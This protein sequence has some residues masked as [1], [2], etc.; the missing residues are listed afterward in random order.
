MPALLGVPAAAHPTQANAQRASIPD[1]IASGH[2]ATQRSSQG[3]A[4]SQQVQAPAEV[5]GSQQAQASEVALAAGGPVLLQHAR[6]ASE[7]AAAQQLYATGLAG[8]AVQQ[9]S[10]RQAAASPQAAQPAARAP[11]TPGSDIEIDLDTPSKPAPPVAAEDALLTGSQRAMRQPSGRALL[12]PTKPASTSTGA[13]HAA[14]GRS[15]HWR[16][17]LPAMPVDPDSSCWRAPLLKCI[18]VLLRSALVSALPVQTAPWPGCLPGTGLQTTFPQAVWRL[19]RWPA[20]TLRLS[21]LPSWCVPQYAGR[22]QL[23]LCRLPW[24]APEPA[25]PHQLQEHHCIAAASTELGG[26]PLCVL[27]ADEERRL[28]Q[29]QAAPLWQQPPQAAKPAG[30][31]CAQP[32]VAA[33]ARSAVPQQPMALADVQPESAAAGS[34]GGQAAGSG[35]AAVMVAGSA[36]GGAASIHHSRPHQRSQAG[37]QQPASHSLSLSVALPVGATDRHQRQQQHPGQ[38]PD[39]GCAQA[40]QSSQH[41]AD[42]KAAPHSPSAPAQP[43]LGPEAMPSQRAEPLQLS[44]GLVDRQ[45]EQPGS[46]D[47]LQGPPEGRTDLHATPAQSADAAQAHSLQQSAGSQPAAPLQLSFSLPGSQRSA[48]RRSHEPRATPGL[49]AAAPEAVAALPPLNGGHSA[50]SA[51]PGSPLGTPGVGKPGAG[52]HAS[53]WLRFALPAP[54]QVRACS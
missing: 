29:G 47:G 43:S 15:V 51:P 3:R 21:R 37:L 26:R 25:L 18:C 5:S 46:Q 14:C 1:A 52:S 17:P 27:G 50:G 24:P 22:C 10:P 6:S 35:P 49:R 2:S 41:K 54:T 45:S 20:S 32:E 40:L 31:G 7:T 30:V 33:A 9:G 53:V 13:T 28:V 12:S 44:L 36:T 34:P 16:G 38:Q 42:P 8:P 4:R 48:E 11:L 23:R 39:S 19:L